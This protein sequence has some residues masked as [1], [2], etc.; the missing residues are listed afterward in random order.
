MKAYPML[1]EDYKQTD[2]DLL[3]N[4]PPTIDY[5]IRYERIPKDFIYQVISNFKKSKL[6][7][8]GSVNLARLAGT[9]F[10]QHFDYLVS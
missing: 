6:W 8:S 7:E 2:K 1:L 10:K 9:V 3:F 4:G 5:L